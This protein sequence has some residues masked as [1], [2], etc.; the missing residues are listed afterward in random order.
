MRIK[1]DAEFQNKIPPLTDEEF[2]NLE[3]LI[4]EEG[5][6]KNPIIVWNGVIVDGHHRWKIIQKHPEIQYEI[7]EKQFADKWEAFDWMYKNQLGRR[8]LTEEQ[9]RYLVGKLYEARKHTHGGDRKS[10]DAVGST[11]E[12]RPLKNSTDGVSAII[13]K[14]QG[15]GKTQV[16][17]SYQ[18]AKGIDAIRETNSELADSILTGEKK[19]AKKVVQ[20]IGRAD[21]IEQEQMIERI[22]NGELNRA[23]NP[24]F[25][26]SPERKCDRVSGKEIREIINSMSDDSDMEYTI[27]HLMEQISANADGFIRVLS[28]LLRDHADLCSEHGTTIAETIR[29]NVIEPINMIVKEN[30]ENET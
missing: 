27:D 2:Q 8:N 25:L 12:S 11:A 16:K 24:E 13:A 15:V 23:I 1:I 26:K 14:E 28:N 30:I 6:V 7:E 20:E 29:R 22:K 19:I 18:F 21:H 5:R 3:E 4:L 17:D 9:K 10:Q